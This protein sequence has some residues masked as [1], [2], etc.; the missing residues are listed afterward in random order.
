MLQDPSNTASWA[1][2]TI[3][4]DV[5]LKKLIW[6]DNPQN[7]PSIFAWIDRDVLFDSI[8]DVYRKIGVL[9][10]AKW[11]IIMKEWDWQC[12]EFFLLLK[13]KIEIHKGKKHIADLDE[14]RVVWEMWFFW[15]EI[16]WKTRKRT[17]TVKAWEECYMLPL[18]KSFML[19]LPAADRIAILENLLAEM[20][21]KLTE[22]NENTCVERCL[23]LKGKDPEQVAQETQRIVD[24]L[25]I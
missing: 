25:M 5:I 14:L 8:K 2:S 21:Y 1:I 4:I 16:N 11:E 17:A 19:S 23:A 9:K 22:M 6:Y 7:T 12:Y 20:I 10:Y 3:D 24:N 13:W 18:N 15:K